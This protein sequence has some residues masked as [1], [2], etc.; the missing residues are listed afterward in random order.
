MLRDIEQGKKS[1]RKPDEIQSEIADLNNY[2]RRIRRADQAFLLSM[3]A[4]FLPRDIAALEAI[5]QRTP[6]QEKN[7]QILKRLKDEVVARDVVFSRR[8]LEQVRLSGMLD[9]SRNVMDGT[10]SPDGILSQPLD[11]F[12]AV[13]EVAGLPVIL[14]RAMTQALDTYGKSLFSRKAAFGREAF[15][16]P[17]ASR[18]VQ[19]A[20]T[21]RGVRKPAWTDT[22]AA[23]KEMWEWFH[24][25]RVES[26][27]VI[28]FGVENMRSRVGETARELQN[29]KKQ[30]SEAQGRILRFPNHKQKAKWLE[31]EA[32]VTD[33]IGVVEA[34]FQEQ[35]ARLAD[36]E[37]ASAATHDGRRSAD[38][39]KRRAQA[40][41]ALALLDFLDAGAPEGMAKVK[42]PKLEHVP[43]GASQAQADAILGRNRR[44]DGDGNRNS[45]DPEEAPERKTGGVTGIHPTFSDQLPDRAEDVVTEQNQ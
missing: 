4:D 42:A 3:Q 28:R 31:D 22:H 9:Q 18:P 36:A 6:V 7:L 19:I 12:Y 13:S 20:T 33:R 30:Q 23:G 32:R 15:L 2:L 27:E 17:S 25:R 35:A 8:S 11:R 24:D 1:K 21:E 16:D 40:L 29:L 38:P 26:P 39:A 44:A 43:A 5:Q 10:F 41:E 45:R 34:R 37:S 14:P